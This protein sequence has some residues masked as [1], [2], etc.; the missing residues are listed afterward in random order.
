MPPPASAVVDDPGAVKI[1]REV[2]LVD[3]VTPPPNPSGNQATPPAQNKVRV[4]RYRVDADPPRAARSIVVMMPGF[5]AGAGAFDSIA[6]AVV[7]RSTDADALEAWAIDRRANL[8]E[9]TFAL[10]VAEVRRDPQIARGYYFDSDTVEGKTFDGFQT[11]P[12]FPWASE[13][14]I[15][16]TVGDLHQVLAL[17]PDVDRSARIVLLGH[18]L[19]ASIVEEYAAWD[20]AGTPGYKDLAGLVLVDGVT[21]TEGNATPPIDQP[22]YENGNNASGLN[23]AIGVNSDI[24]AGNVFVALPFLGVKAYVV[25]EY[26]SMAARFTPTAVESDSTRDGLLGVTLGLSPVPKMTNHAALGLAFDEQYAP[27]VFVAASLGEPSGG[28]VGPYQSALGGTQMH[29]TD[30]NATYDWVDF[31]KTTPVENTS[32]DDFARSWYE[33]PGLNLAEWYFPQRL[34]LDAQ[35][36]GT[37]DI[38]DSDWRSSAYG[39]KA[40]NGAAIDVPILA[41]ALA[42]IGKASAF[43]ALKATV[44]QTIGAGRPSA[45]KT[46]SDP[47]A[48]TAVALPQL[49]HVDG[50]AGADAQGSAVKGWYDALVAFALK[51]TPAGGVVVPIQK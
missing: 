40:K 48:F 39:L 51:Q 23:K 10:D 24:R 26:V 13:W 49:Q 20:F 9:D 45:G 31:D 7:R 1:R 6:R 11:G 35:A 8:L 5:L 37:L 38:A 21:Q 42:L 47:D 22:T 28:S 12:Q 2:F 43:D 17:V 29:P 34:V 3:G 44:A 46:R 4:V 33:G 15:A 27:F 36:A 41:Y 14:G 16:T 50:V 32:I 19:G 25:A 30:P 18:S